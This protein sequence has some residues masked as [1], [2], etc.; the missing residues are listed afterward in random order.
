M[1]ERTKRQVNVWMLIA[2]MFGFAFGLIPLIMHVYW[3]RYQRGVTVFGT[4][5][6]TSVPTSNLAAEAVRYRDGMATMF[7]ALAEGVRSGKIADR[8]QAVDFAREYGK[9]L[10]KVMDSTYDRYSDDK[11]RISRPELLADEF[12]TAAR[13]LGAKR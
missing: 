8:R 4:P 5:A 1:V 7:R 11:E 9:P 10:A 2:F 3:L 12:E 6:T 13:V